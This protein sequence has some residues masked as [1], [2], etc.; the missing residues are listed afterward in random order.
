MT[1]GQP[2]PYLCLYR[3]VRIMLTGRPSGVT[4]QASH[5]S[6]T[7]PSGCPH[8]SSD[9]PLDKSHGPTHSQSIRPLDQY[10]VIVRFVTRS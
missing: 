6:A 1:T 9:S 7:L 8:P 2:A 4:L 3:N 10:S 5:S